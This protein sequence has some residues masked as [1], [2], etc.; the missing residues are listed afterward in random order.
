MRQPAWEGVMGENGYVYMYGWV[1]SL[2]T[3]NYHNIVNWLYPHKNVFGV[4]NKKEMSRDFPGGPV[5][6]NL[7]SIA[8]DEGSIPGQG[9]K[10]TYA[11]GQL[12]PLT[13]TGEADMHP[14]LK[15]KHDHNKQI[16]EVIKLLF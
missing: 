16:K 6:K 5:V 7:P 9:T 1:P 12:S 4:K 14:G 3:Q 13:T 2:F 11:T 10:I 8:G 15:T